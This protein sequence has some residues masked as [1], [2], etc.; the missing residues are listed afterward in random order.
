MNDN[1]YNDITDKGI[2]ITRGLT[3]LKDRFQ[4]K[5]DPKQVETQNWKYTKFPKTGSGGKDHGILQ[6]DFTLIL[7]ITS[8]SCY[9]HQIFFIIQSWTIWFDMIFFTHGMTF[10]AFQL[11]DKF[12]TMKKQKH[13]G[14]FLEINFHFQINHNNI[15][16]RTADAF[17]I[18]ASTGNASAVWG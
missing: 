4:L 14:I 17:P 16:L 1:L 11:K 3:I 13:Q 6:E 10:L 5:T 2:F 15:S 8:S 7:I 9:F 12:S 18:V